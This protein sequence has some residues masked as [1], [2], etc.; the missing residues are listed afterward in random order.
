[1][2]KLRFADEYGQA[3]DAPINALAYELS[4]GGD[5]VRGKPHTHTALKSHVWQTLQRYDIAAR[6]DRREVDRR[7]DLWL[8]VNEERNEDKK[9][10]M[11]VADRISEQTRG[12]KQED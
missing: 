6:F 7:M 10:A 11:I 8:K 5:L 3:V 4:E 12:R 1:M 2:T 9:H